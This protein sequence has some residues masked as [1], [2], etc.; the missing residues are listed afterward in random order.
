MNTFTEIILLLL[1]FL[2]ITTASI[3]IGKWFPKIKLPLITGFI[4]IGIL[5]GPSVAG[6][7]DKSLVDKGTFINDF[8]LAFIAMAAGAELYFNELR[9]RI[10]SILWMTFG[11]LAITFAVGLLFVY[12]LLNQIQ[13]FSYLSQHAK[14]AFAMLAATI[15]VARS[16]SSGMAIITEMRARGPFTQ[17]AIG[18]TV[19]KDV[20]VIALFTLTFGIAV[21]ITSANGFRIQ[22]LLFLSLE[23]LASVVLGFIS[24][25]LIQFLMRI[26][27]RYYLKLVSIIVFGFLIFLSTKI[28]HNYTLVKYHEAFHIEPLLVCILASFYV[29]NFCSARAEFLKILDE[30]GPIIYAIFFTYTGLSLSLE[31]LQSVWGLALV[32]FGVRLFSIILGGFVG[33][34]LANEPRKFILLSWMPFVTQAGVGLG[35]AAL[36]ASRF[37]GWGSEFATIII[38]SII[39][40]QIVGPPLFKWSL[41]MVQ[42]SHQRGTSEHEENYALIFG[43][44]SQSL[45]L[46]KQLIAHRWKVRIATIYENIN[47]NEFKWV[48]IIKIQDFNLEALERL[49]ASKAHAIVC[50]NTDEENLIVCEL[51]YE[52][53]GTKDLIVRLQNPKNLH[54]FRELGAIVVDPR[55][56]M[57][58]LLDHF[59]RSPLATSIILGMDE[60][61]DTV[62]LEINNPDLHGIFI[63]QLR[64]PSDLLILSIFRNGQTLIS[65]GYTRLR[66]GDIVTVVG[67]PESIEKFSLRFEAVSVLN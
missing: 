22:S 60:N 62:D 8:S 25:K 61:Q 4:F 35:L 9:G 20:L 56:A 40:S 19:I 63:R 44:E 3:Q 10:K 12:F 46:A 27:K 28:V 26:E 47:I 30:V 65:H 2:I 33:G 15:F 7:I 32:F 55:T 51:A 38:A 66:M 14:W 45:A 16:P 17:M 42:E 5:A 41:N 39:V 59:V 64:I 43:L 36:V 13:Q 50:H 31:T 11:Q 54:K 67:S 6:M 24:G 21:A 57:V 49:D 53:Y 23:M 29:S 52:Q 58:N 48:E 1:S 37:V 34:I 18:V